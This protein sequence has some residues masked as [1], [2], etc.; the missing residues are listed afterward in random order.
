MR[1]AASSSPA[2]NLLAGA[3]LRHKA[4]GRPSRSG[5]DDGR[6]A[7]RTDDASA[8]RLDGVTLQRGS[9]SPYDVGFTHVIG[10]AVT[11]TT[12]TTGAAPRIRATNST[13]A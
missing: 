9:A 12:T 11:N 2:I 5:A 8:V 13:P 4:T 3:A 7:F 10:F 6:P 1:R